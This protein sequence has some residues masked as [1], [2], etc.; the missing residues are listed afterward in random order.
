M[1]APDGKM[2]LTDVADTEQVLR[3]IRQP[4]GFSESAT[5]A[6]EGANAAKVARKQIEKSTSKSAISKLNAQKLRQRR[7]KKGNGD[8]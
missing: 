6:K 3:L 4:V 2:R 7:L 1:I 5:V 8:G